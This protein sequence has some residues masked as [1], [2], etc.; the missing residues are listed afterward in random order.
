[1]RAAPLSVLLSRLK[2]KED[3][4]SGPGSVDSNRRLPVTGFFLVAG[5][6]G[7][8]HPTLKGCQNGLIRGSHVVRSHQRD[9]GSLN[10][11]VL[12][13]YLLYHRLLPVGS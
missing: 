8:T 9:F 10:P 2:G 7:F 5:C 3:R 13:N 4:I 6:P 1:M 11:R 12:T